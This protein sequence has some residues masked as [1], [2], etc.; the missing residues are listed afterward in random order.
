M[1]RGQA[2]EKLQIN[3]ETLRYYEQIG[4][5]EPTYHKDSTYRQY[6]ELTLSRLELILRFKTFGF[7]LKEIKLFFSLLKDSSRNPE[8]FSQFLN[9][10]IEDVDSQ[11]E[12]LSQVKNSLISFRDRED[13]DSCQLFSKFRD[14]P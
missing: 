8:I 13:K 7:S 1:T 11:I 12:G 14:T 5:I 9:K 2:A 4:L 6:D 10:K 3:K